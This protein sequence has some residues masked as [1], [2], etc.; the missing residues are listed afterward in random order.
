MVSDFGG[1]RSGSCGKKETTKAEYGFDAMAVVIERC[2]PRPACRT[3]F[4]MMR[5]VCSLHY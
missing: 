4:T 2:A 3:D 5:A 1:N